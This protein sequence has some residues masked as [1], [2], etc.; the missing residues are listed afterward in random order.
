MTEKNIVAIIQARVASKRFPRKVLKKLNGKNLI[1]W[2]LN[3]IKKCAEIDKICVATTQDPSDDELVNILEN[4]N[5]FVFR[6][7]T[8]DVLS[9]YYDAALITEATHIVRITADCPFVDPCIITKVINLFEMKHNLDYVS[10]TLSDTFPD[11]LDVEFFSF[12]ALESAYLNA[13]SFY[14]R[15]HVT[16]YIKNNCS[17]ENL[18]SE[19][20]LARDLRLT[21]DEPIDLK[22]LSEIVKKLSF[23]DTFEF[24]D[25]VNVYKKF[26]EV[27]KE[28]MYLKR[29]FGS[30][31]TSANKIWKRAKKVIPGGTMLFSKRPELFIPDLWPTYYKK[32]KGISVW[33]MDLNHYFDFSYMGVGT[34]TL[35]YG[36]E[37]VD[38]AVSRVVESGNLCTLNNP[39]EVLL[40]E[41]LI[42][43][44]PGQ[45][46]VRFTR[47]GGEANAVAIRIARAASSKTKVAICGYHGWH[48]W[49]LSANHEN[50]NNLNTHLLS[51]LSV[52]GVPEELSG[53][54]IPFLYNDIKKLEDIVVNNEISAVK[55]EVKRNIDPKPM[56]LKEVR[57]LCDK[58]NVILIF[59]ECTSGFRETYGGLYKKFNVIPD[60]L[61]YG[62]TLGNGYA[63]NAILGKRE[64]ME[65]AQK[66]FISSTFWTEAI[67]TAAAIATLREM[68][69]IKSWHI[70]SDLGEYFYNG[71]TQIA[72]NHSIK[73]NISGLKPLLSFTF[74]KWHLERKTFLTKEML[75][76]GW[77]GTN[78]FY[79]STCHTKEKIDDYLNDLDSIFN[80]IKNLDFDNNIV[81]K[82]NIGKLSHVGF[83][84]L[85]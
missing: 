82:K 25:I 57:K 14:E 30:C 24:L 5:F 34:N 21:V 71:L 7:D 49:Y 37:A 6:G 42:D 3:R 81:R 1:L 23:T 2:V 51:G 62:K 4:E 61:I 73:I 77:L 52:D 40:A 65:A 58:H 29:N 9:R 70:I 83:K 72:L 39:D 11:G 26:P 68:K 16:P 27:F 76:L 12:K 19:Y 36:C 31:M 48:D 74:E 13:K 10:N 75:K 66:T 33:D 84:R 80:T 59:D 53:L 46:M 67:G 54:T 50:T 15:E 8:E 17:V 79:A 22:V 18:I 69:E 60:M 56:F 32:C 45:E 41:Q 35:G 38:K 28:N 43:I 63:V 78:A 55:M 47:S 20:P 85:N 64:V 44:S